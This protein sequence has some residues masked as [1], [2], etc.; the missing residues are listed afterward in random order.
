MASVAVLGRATPL[1]LLQRG[2]RP[3]TSLRV[4]QHFPVATHLA[5]ST[6]LTAG[7]PVAPL[8]N[9]TVTWRSRLPQ[10]L[11][12]GRDNPLVAARALLVVV[13]NVVEQGR[14]VVLRNSCGHSL[15]I[16]S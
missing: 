5:D 13:C 7:T 10:L 2:T 15:V 8:A 3:P 9:T 1:G 6:R 4:A 11:L 14:L 16:S 12:V